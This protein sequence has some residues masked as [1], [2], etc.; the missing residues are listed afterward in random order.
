MLFKEQSSERREAMAGDLERDLLMEHMKSLAAPALDLE[1]R[2]LYSYAGDEE[3]E[4]FLRWML[5]WLA[6]QI[7]SGRNFELLQAYLYRVMV[8][9]D[10]ALLDIPSLGP[11][12]ADLKKANEIASERFRHLIQKNLCMFKVFANIPFT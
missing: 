4:L 8:I 10:K 7:A 9:F 3:G 5:E 1:L 2:A 12:L 6:I 11:V